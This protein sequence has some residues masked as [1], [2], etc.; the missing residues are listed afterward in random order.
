MRQMVVVENQPVPRD[1]FEACFLG[2]YPRIYGILYRLTGDPGDA[3]DL[4]IETFLRLWR[5]APVSLEN[6]GGWLSRVAMRLGFNSLRSRKRR[7][8]YEEQAAG[9]EWLRQFGPDPQRHA[10]TIAQRLRVR[11]VLKKMA[12]RDARILLLHHSGHSYKEI[13]SALKLNPNSIGVMLIRAEKEFE[14]IYRKGD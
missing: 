10:E 8:H 9:E 3:E 12:H 1:E 2:H 6:T 7:N 5:R 13:A 4:A 11:S 14:R